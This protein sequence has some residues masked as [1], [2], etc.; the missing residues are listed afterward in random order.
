MNTSIT[1][2]DA[3]A[4]S[5]ASGEVSAEIE[6]G[7]SPSTSTRQLA[8]ALL[9]AAVDVGVEQADRD[10]LDVAALE[11]LELPP[12]L[13]LVERGQHAAVGEHPLGDAAAQV[14]R[15][16]R[17]GGV[18]ERPAPARVGLRVE[19]PPQPPLIEDVAE[20]LGGQERRPS[21]AGG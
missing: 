18:A 2:V 14:A 4:Y 1:V 11:H 5:L 10:A 6:T 8:Q 13:V 7:T 3:R 20:A 9:V 16:E 15:D 12:R 21:A 19:R 17:P